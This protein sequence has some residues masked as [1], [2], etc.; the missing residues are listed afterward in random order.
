MKPLA[1]TQ[2]MFVWLCI[3]PDENVPNRWKK[4]SY[5]CFA[6]INLLVLVSALTSSV[7]FAVKFASTN[8]PETLGAC[9]QFAGWSTVCYLLLIS[10]FMREKVSAIFTELAVIYNTSEYFLKNNYSNKIYLKKWNFYLNLDKN[11]ASFQFLEQ[12]NNTSEMLC[13][14]FFKYFG[15]CVI[16]V[17]FGIDGV[18]ILYSFYEFDNF[19]PDYICY[20]MKLM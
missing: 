7:L 18:S 2:K 17:S 16:T 11:K 5:I 4:L 19:N 1:S 9:T 12:A 14:F 10:L 3:C 8:L 20:S 15:L 6:A 13:K